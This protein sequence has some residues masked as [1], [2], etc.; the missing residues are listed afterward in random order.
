M[1]APK[2]F[3]L[4]IELIDFLRGVNASELISR[5]LNEHINE[6]ALENMTEKQCQTELKVIK[7]Q[8]KMD[9]TIKKLRKDAQ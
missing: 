1:K 9:K 8:Q 7:L 6:D 4:N 2:M 3:Y 5:L